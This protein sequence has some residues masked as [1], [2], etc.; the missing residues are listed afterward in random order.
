VTEFPAP[1]TPGTWGRESR[2]LLTWLQAEGILTALS[3]NANGYAPGPSWEKAIAAQHK[4]SEIPPDSI[5]DVELRM[6][7]L[8][9]EGLLTRI[10]GFGYYVN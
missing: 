2:A 7:M 5:M 10:P 3:D 9:D 1:T 4:V 6:N 8:E